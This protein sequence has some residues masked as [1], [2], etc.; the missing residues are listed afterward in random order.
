MDG[1]G[2][3]HRWGGRSGSCACSRAGARAALCMLAPWRTVTEGVSLVGSLG[4]LRIGAAQ[5][6][7]RP[8]SLHVDRLAGG[9]SAAD[10]LSCHQA[11]WRTCQ[12][13]YLVGLCH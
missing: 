6:T 11:H 5:M 7:S 1:A 12:A 8:G 2:K 4:N 10:K 3:G 9:G 13:A